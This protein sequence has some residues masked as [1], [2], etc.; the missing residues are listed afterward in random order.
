[1]SILPCV[2]MACRYERWCLKHAMTLLWRWAC[3]MLSISFLSTAIAFIPTVG[4]GRFLMVMFLFLLE[5]FLRLGPGQPC[6]KENFGK[7]LKYRFKPVNFANWIIW[8]RSRK[9]FCSVGGRSRVLP[10]GHTHGHARI[11][12]RSISGEPRCRFL[13]FFQGK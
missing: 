11:T 9:N 2:S 8:S 3:G 6:S 10:P 1:M 5:K 4:K 12:K 7:V 13:S